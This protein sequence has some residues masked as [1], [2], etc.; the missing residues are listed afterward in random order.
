[1]QNCN[2]NIKETGLLEL[3]ACRP[4][5]AAWL[6]ATVK[7]ERKNL[8]VCHSHTCCLFSCHF[9]VGTNEEDNPFIKAKQA[10]N[11]QRFLVYKRAHPM[12]C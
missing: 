6:E 1:M 4:A 2:S 12:Q 7:Y 10:S 9:I 11:G 8:T 3:A 5:M